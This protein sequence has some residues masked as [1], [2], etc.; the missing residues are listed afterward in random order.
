MKSLYDYLSR[1]KVEAKKVKKQNRI[2]KMT[3]ETHEL[4]GEL[5]GLEM[6]LKTHQQE[7]R[8][9]VFSHACEIGRMQ[10]N[11]AKKQGI[12]LGKKKV[13]A[14]LEAEFAVEYGV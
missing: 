11:V 8:L 3:I 10:V 14:R 9:L 13:L 6:E 7:A 4:A 12:L 2:D 5:V 1:R